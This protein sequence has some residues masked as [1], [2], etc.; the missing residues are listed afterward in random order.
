MLTSLIVTNTQGLFCIYAIY[1]QVANDRFTTTYKLST[2]RKYREL[3]NPTSALLFNVINIDCSQLH[4]DGRYSR[5]DVIDKHIMYLTRNHP[6]A[7]Q[8]NGAAA[9]LL[10]HLLFSLSFLLLPYY[11]GVL[12]GWMSHICTA[13]PFIKSRKAEFYQ[14][15]SCR[16]VEAAAKALM[17]FSHWCLVLLWEHIQEMS[18]SMPLAPAHLRR[19]KLSKSYAP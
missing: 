18:K 10:N 9:L 3:H 4:T 13:Q 1:F 15:S 17:G 11:L 8:S 7:T 16:P 12:Y 6:Q 2:R 19:P 14:M 5:C